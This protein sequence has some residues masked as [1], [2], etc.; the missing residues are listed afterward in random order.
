MSLSGDMDLKKVVRLVHQKGVVTAA[1]LRGQG[2]SY[3][4]MLKYRHGKWLAAL[5]TGAFCEPGSSPTLDAALAAL[6][7]Q[8]GLPV[9]L[10]GKTAL[11]RRGIMQQ[12]PLGGHT[13]EVYLRRGIRMPKWFCDAYA[14]QFV[15]NSSNLLPD[16]TGVEHGDDGVF[17]SSP[18]R[19]YLEVAAEVPGKVPVGELYQLMEF[20]ETLRPGLVTELLSKCRSVKAKRV[21]LFLAD[22]LG[23]WWAKK[24]DRS[25]IHLGTG[26]RVIDKG[27]TFQSKYNIVVAPWRET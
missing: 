16:E 6:C 5:G 27:G 10:G 23:H 22:D 2:V 15:R 24:L 1:W 18:E 13:A 17:L 4:N 20:A 19:A 21:F 7:E 12:V 3:Q 8:L 26:C 11:L 25:A 9:H 14:G